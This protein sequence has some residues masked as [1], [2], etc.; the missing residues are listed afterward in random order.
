MNKHVD[1]P[2]RRPGLSDHAKSVL[3]GRLERCRAGR[4]H[5][6]THLIGC[7]HFL[8]LQLYWPGSAYEF[9]SEILDGITI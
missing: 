3:Y 2:G 1:R 7:Q 5:L 8:W 9:G 6:Y 4:L